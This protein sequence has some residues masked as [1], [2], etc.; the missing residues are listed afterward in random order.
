M[1]SHKVYGK[2]YKPYN[3]I[4]LAFDQTKFDGNKGKLVRPSGVDLAWRDLCVLDETCVSAYLCPIGLESLLLLFYGA[5]ELSQPARKP[6]RLGHR[7]FMIKSSQAA[8]SSLIN[9]KNT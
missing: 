7:S 5:Q 8:F 9:F 6:N 4:N 2:S 3:G 1:Y